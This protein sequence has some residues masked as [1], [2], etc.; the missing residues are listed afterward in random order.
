MMRANRTAIDVSPE[1]SYSGAAKAALVLLAMDRSQAL[2]ILKSLAPE[3][4]RA[5]MRRAAELKLVEGTLLDAIITEFESSFNEG[6]NF[7][8]SAD[9]VRLLV[10][11]ALGN[12][13]ANLALTA[14]AVV[15][16]P[17]DPPWTE[18]GQLSDDVLVAYILGQHP[19]AAAFLL[20]NLEQD[21]SADLLRSMVPDIANDLLARL[22]TVKELPKTIQRAFEEAVRE[23]LISKTKSGSGAHQ[24]VA[25]VLNELNQERSVGALDYISLHRPEDARIV[26]KMLFKFE[27]LPRLSARSLGVVVERLPVERIVI[28]LR[29]A[30]PA[31]QEVVLGA[32]APRARRMAE[33][34][35]KNDSPSPA[36]AV[37]EAKRIVAQAVLNLA[38]TGA[39]ELP[40]AVENES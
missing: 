14:P 39:I 16:A 21:K 31:L 17:L 10:E 8:G 38:S 33:S 7:I 19:Q 29:N 32:M 11:E 27:D 3:D 9:E 23:D 6:V 26:R 30:S 36:K 40:N 12:D 2:E 37:T 22:L 35:L 34:E 20:A 15:E 24:L 28:A 1:P 5:I 18:V 13:G 4:V 25:G